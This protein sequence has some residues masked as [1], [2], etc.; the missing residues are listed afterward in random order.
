M[1][2]GFGLSGSPVLLMILS[3]RQMEQCGLGPVDGAS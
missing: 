1:E 2:K 3:G